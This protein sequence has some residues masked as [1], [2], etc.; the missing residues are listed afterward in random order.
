MTCRPEEGFGAEA[1]GGTIKIPQIVKILKQ[2]SDCYGGVSFI[3]ALETGYLVEAQY[4]HTVDA[5]SL[6]KHAEESLALSQEEYEF[7]LF[8]PPRSEQQVLVNP[9]L[10][11]RDHIPRRLGSIKIRPEFFEQVETAREESEREDLETEIG[12]T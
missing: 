9:L 11:R 2:S 5:K 3:L 6:A 8:P 7:F 12:L 4:V 10:L 1:G